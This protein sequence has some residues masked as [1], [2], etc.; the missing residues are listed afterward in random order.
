MMD[1]YRK[2]AGEY[3]WP[4]NGVTVLE[5]DGKL[6]ALVEWFS[7]Q[8]LEHVDGDTFKLPWISGY[9]DEVVTFHRDAGGTATAVQIGGDVTLERREGC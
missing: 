4:Q 8:P 9:A 5:K 6:Y 1:G 3:G 7:L 2:L